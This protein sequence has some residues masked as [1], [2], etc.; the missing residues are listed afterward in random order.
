MFWI[1]SMDWN[2]WRSL[3]FQEGSHAFVFHVSEAL[4]LKWWRTQSRSCWEP[5]RQLPIGISFGELGREAHLFPL[6]L[7]RSLRKGGAQKDG[8]EEVG[9]SS[10]QKQFGEPCSGSGT[11]ACR[12]QWLAPRWNTGRNGTPNKTGTHYHDFSLYKGPCAQASRGTSWAVWRMIRDPFFEYS[13]LEKTLTFLCY[14]REEK[15]AAQNKTSWFF[16]P[17]RWLKVYSRLSNLENGKK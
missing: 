11:S 6:P 1:S 10:N 2:R 8:E 7:K 17:D 5:K 14:P 9:Q 12:W 13:W 3:S 16:L 4:E 15:G